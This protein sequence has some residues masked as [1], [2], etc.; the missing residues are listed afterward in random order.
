[1]NKQT[2][3]YLGVGV[4]VLAA[5]YFW[6]KSKNSPKANASGK[7]NQPCVFYD[8]EELIKGRTS[9]YDSNLCVSNV[10]KKGPKEKL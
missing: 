7:G 8:G 3:M 2:K 9:T 6:N 10:G 5:Y 1:M 4:L